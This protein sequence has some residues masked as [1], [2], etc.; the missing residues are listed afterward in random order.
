[1]IGTEKLALL[2]ALAAL[3]PGLA[4]GLA[5]AA[6]PNAA[7]GRVTFIRQCGLCHSVRA[8]EVLTAPSLAGVVGRK[9]GTA[10]G[11]RASAALKAW[12]R[13]WDAP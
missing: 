12:G 5:Q 8:G 2:A 9:A 11:Y 7:A 6:E 3:S 1:M 4:P 10:P 13:R